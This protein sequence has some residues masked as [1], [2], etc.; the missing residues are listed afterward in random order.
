MDFLSSSEA[1]SPTD[2]Y[3]SRLE[4]HRIWLFVVLFLDV[5]SFFESYEMAQAVGVTET[6]A[7]PY[8]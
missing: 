7:T 6:S 3:Y 5:A 4:H 8:Y 1:L 2:D